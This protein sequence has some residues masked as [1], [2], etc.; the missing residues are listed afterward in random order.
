VMYCDE[1]LG[2]SILLLGCLPADRHSGP[3]LAA[4][5]GGVFLMCVCV[6]GCLLFVMLVL[7]SLPFSS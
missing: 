2:H 3:A 4:W 1:P 6:C 7:G 5:L